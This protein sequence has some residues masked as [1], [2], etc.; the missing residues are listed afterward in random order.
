M[1]PRSGVRGSWM[2]ETLT[3]GLADPST[4]AGRALGWAADPKKRLGLLIPKK[5]WSVAQELVL[6]YQCR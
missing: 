2:W 5:G 6:P 4:T 3:A 1:L